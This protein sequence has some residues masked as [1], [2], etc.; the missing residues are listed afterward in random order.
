VK[1]QHSE[2]TVHCPSCG[3]IFIKQ[4]NLDIHIANGICDK[5]RVK[6]LKSKKKRS[7][8]R[9][10]FI[11]NICG[12]IFKERRKLKEHIMWKHEPLEFGCDQCKYKAPSEKYVVEHKAYK[13]EGKGPM[14][15][16]CDYVA[17]FK[18]SLK[19][20]LLNVHGVGVKVPTEP[21]PC[22]YQ[23]CHKIYANKVGLERHIMLH[24]GERPYKCDYC[25]KAFIQKG[26]LQ[27]HVRVHTGD[28]PFKCSYCDKA[29]T[30]SSALKSHMKNHIKVDYANSLY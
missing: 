6:N 1:I 19:I 24:T 2:T 7:R 18:S 30:Q 23:G 10:A 27:E 12:K 28:K 26:T 13:H 16:Q 22:P 20:H 9:N 3:K 8:A 21:V 15:D 17:K 5:D 14:C 11:C 25:E 29:F 4:A